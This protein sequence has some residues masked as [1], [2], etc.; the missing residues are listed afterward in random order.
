VAVTNRRGCDEG[1]P[2]EVTGEVTLRCI[3]TLA[4]KCFDMPKRAAVARLGARVS[5]Q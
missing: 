4:T 3:R 5:R 2:E 1:G